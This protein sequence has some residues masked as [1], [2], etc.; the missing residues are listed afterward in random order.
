MLPD[1]LAC[2]SSSVLDSTS[3]CPTDALQNDLSIDAC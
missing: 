3:S 2:P 1:R